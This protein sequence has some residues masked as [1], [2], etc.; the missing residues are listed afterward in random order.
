MGEMTKKLPN[1]FLHDFRAKR[2]DSARCKDL[3][4]QQTLGNMV[5]T[6]SLSQGPQMSHVLL[7]LETTPAALTTMGLW[8]RLVRQRP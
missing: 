5:L 3:E 6:H 8:A 1:N 7:W 4:A 2:E